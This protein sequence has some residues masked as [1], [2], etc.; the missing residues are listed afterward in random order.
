MEF[1]REQIK[2]KER[3]KEIEKNIQTLLKKETTISLTNLV[4]FWAYYYV[5]SKRTCKE[6]VELAAFK[7]RLKIRDGRIFK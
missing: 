2:K 7:L 1:T 3:I 5:I 4:N 6:Y